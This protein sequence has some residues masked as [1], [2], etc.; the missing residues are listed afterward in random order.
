MFSLMTEA[1]IEIPLHSPDD[2]VSAGILD[3]PMSTLRLDRPQPA[4]HD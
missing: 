3:W 2:E 1:P 4:A